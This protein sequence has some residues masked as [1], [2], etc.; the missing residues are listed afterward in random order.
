MTLPFCLFR[1]RFTFQLR[2]CGFA[3]SSLA[4]GC[5]MICFGE[6]GTHQER[7]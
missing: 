1:D 2:R 5:L 7:P 3:D 4:M 6:V